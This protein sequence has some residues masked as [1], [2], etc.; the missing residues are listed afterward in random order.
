MNGVVS[1]D[2]ESSTMNE[3]VLP[4]LVIESL[5]YGDVVPMPTLLK[6][7]EMPETISA[8]VLDAAVEVALC[9]TRSSVRTA[10]DSVVV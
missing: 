2:V 5:A 4:V 9:P 7:L 3:G 1:G 6:K 8:G 10:S